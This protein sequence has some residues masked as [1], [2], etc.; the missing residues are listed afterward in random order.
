MSGLGANAESTRIRL[1]R[2]AVVASNIADISRRKPAEII[3]P[4]ISD[5]VT[6]KTTMNQHTY[7]LQ[8]AILCPIMYSQADALC[9]SNT[10]P[11]YTPQIPYLPTATEGPQGPGVPVVERQFDRISGI[12]VICKPIPKR[13]SSSR[14]AQIRVG[15]ETAASTTRYGQTVLPLIPYPEYIPTPSGPQAGVPEARA[16]NCVR[17]L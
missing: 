14:T 16:P 8:K 12:D 3:C 9:G 6:E 5:T 15:L 4:D 10:Q 13:A 2:E 17:P 1:L 7:I 11:V